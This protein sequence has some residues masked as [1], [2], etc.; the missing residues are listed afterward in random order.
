M[1]HK[2][3]QVYPTDDYKV[4]IYFV[5][6][7]IK[8]FDAK[9]LVEKGIFKQLRD[10]KMFKEACTVINDTLAWDLSGKRDPY[11]C[12]DLDP[13]EL[14]ENCPEVKEPNINRALLN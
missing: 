2:V 10:K 1:F 12:L 14:Y 11:E 9:D 13:E 7:K 8:Q 5:D 6:G 3:V 4:Y